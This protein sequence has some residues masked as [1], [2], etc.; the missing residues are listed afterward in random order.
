MLN[1]K[2]LI[3]IG[4]TA[5]VAAAA[6]AGVMVFGGKEESKP[7][8]SQASD[9]L[10]PVTQAPTEASLPEIDDFSEEASLTGRAKML[11]RENED[12]VGYIKISNTYVDYPVVQYDGEDLDENGND[13]YLHKDLYG[14]YLESGTIFMDYRDVFE[15]DES[16]QSENI[17][18]YG[19][20]ML[21][22]TNLSAEKP[23]FRRSV[24][25]ML[26]E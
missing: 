13:Y 19:H 21:N 6:L 11:L 10:A 3:T 22:G 8:S 2:T 5:V 18:L 26:A 16:K 23:F 20:N 14:N 25:S 17:V 7:G 1:K 15:A 9:V 12:V 4:C 24:I